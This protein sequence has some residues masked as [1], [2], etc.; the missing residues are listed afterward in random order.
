MTIDPIRI[1]PTSQTLLEGDDPVV[2]VTQAGERDSPSRAASTSVANTRVVVLSE[3]VIRIMSVPAFAARWA[4]TLSVR[5]RAWPVPSSES[6]MV[7]PLKPSSSR[8]SRMAIA[9]DQPAAL[10][11]S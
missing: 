3:P 7:T 5:P 2:G 4:S 6:V 10:S 8:A 9:S 11:G 1:M